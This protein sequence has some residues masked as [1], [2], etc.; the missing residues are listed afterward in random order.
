MEDRL[1]ELEAMQKVLL[2]GT[3][4]LPF[5]KMMPN[6]IYSPLTKQKDGSSNSIFLAEAY[7]KLQNDLILAKQRLAKI[8]QSKDKKATV[9]KVTNRLL[10]DISLC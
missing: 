2:E 8:L 6:S 5:E 4:L 1:I 9:S 3:G 10:L 7:D